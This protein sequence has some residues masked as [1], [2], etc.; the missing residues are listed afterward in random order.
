[1]NLSL[2]KAVRRS[3]KR[4]PPQIRCP[5]D[6]VASVATHQQNL[7]QIDWATAG[8][9]PEEGWRFFRPL[10][11]VQKWTRRRQNSAEGRC[12]VT[13]RHNAEEELLLLEGLGLDIDLIPRQTS[14]QTGILAPSHRARA[15]REPLL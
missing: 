7:M 3:A 1:M 8:V 2:Q 11:C 9:Q 12:P 13:R 6:L 14:G 10:L 5:E 4:N 15:L